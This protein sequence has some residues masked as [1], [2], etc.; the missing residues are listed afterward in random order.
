MNSETENKKTLKEKGINKL[1]VLALVLGA[2]GGLV[3]GIQLLDF[4]EKGFPA[5]SGGIHVAL[6]AVLVFELLA[7]VAVWFAVKKKTV[8]GRTGRPGMSEHLLPAV[9]M[10]I[11]A[12]C[13]AVRLAMS[14]KP[15]SAWGIIL[16]I[17]CFALAASVPV[18]VRSLGNS[19]V[20]D[21]EKLISLLPVGSMVAIIIELYRSV[22]RTPSASLYATD[23]FAIV[24]LI[25]LFFS[26]AGDVNGRTGPG[27]VVAMSFGFISVGT[28]AFLGRLIAVGRELIGGAGFSCILTHEF[29]E[30]L[31]AL[32]GIAVA[33]AVANAVGRRGERP[34][35]AETEETAPEG[36]AE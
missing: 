10:V 24:V 33:F 27:K 17:I 13:A 25:L 28:T 7:A 18:A 16:S 8:C 29:F 20:S 36:D 30:G 11:F 4:D 9:A 31:M 19:A 14:Y 35:E 15:F 34:A 12:L 26:V 23:V 22:A 21:G 32:G 1:L 2:A 3:R 6:W 5:S